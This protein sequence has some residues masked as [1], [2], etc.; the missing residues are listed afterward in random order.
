LKN[1]RTKLF[2]FIAAMGVVT[3]LAACEPATESSSPWVKSD[4]PWGKRTAAVTE[5]AEA[6]AADT[7]KQELAEI[8][9][10]TTGG[11]EMGY[12]TEQVE[13]SVPQEIVVE[14]I[15]PQPVAKPVTAKKPKAEKVAPVE[16]VDG[17]DTAGDFRNIA[18]N[19]YTVQVIA[20][21]DENSVHTFAKK[22][23]L[24]TR[25]IVPTVRGSTTWHVLLLDVY[26]TKA[27]AKSAMEYAAGTLPTKPWIRTVASVQ[28]IMP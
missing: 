16:A 17:T 27:A 12:Q 19:Y 26:P 13:S 18:G 1:Q 21:V 14:E 8:D 24:S 3:L 23:Q 11:V 7:Y 5:S 9:A 4:S 25:Y 22:H 2:P 6:P 20:S 28:Q 10:G 15:A